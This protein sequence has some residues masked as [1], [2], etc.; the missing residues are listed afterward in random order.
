MLHRW[1]ALR[2]A[3]GP[4]ARLNLA[5]ELVKRSVMDLVIA[6]L[7]HVVLSI[8]EWEASHYWRRL[9]RASAVATLPYFVPTA[10][11][12]AWP[13]T[14]KRQRC[15]CLTS[16]AEQGTPFTRDA[17]RQFVAIV[18]ALGDRCHGW[19]FMLT[20]PTDGQRVPSRIRAVG[21][22]DDPMAVLGEARALAVLTEYGHGFKTK[23]L[24][25]AVQHAY[26]LVYPRQFERLPAR[27][28]PYCIVVPS[29]TADGLEH[30]LTQADRAWPGGDVNAG[31]RAEAFATLD[32][33]VARAGMH[34]PRR[35][36]YPADRRT[37]A[38]SRLGGE[39]VS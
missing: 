1:D 25:A 28:Q 6:R 7:S 10:Y 19:E 39:V 21:V 23:L 35:V 8:T 38:H 27:L 12:G 11:L 32:S 20:G 16:I 31:F 37:G 33:L 18:G 30:A 17:A 13:A 4:R 36:G 24:D 5:R 26:P 2:L 14:S 29:A 22:V 3:T 34:T 9:A 15:V